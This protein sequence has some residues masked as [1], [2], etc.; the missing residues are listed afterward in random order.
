MFQT[1]VGATYVP[2]KNNKVRRI[3]STEAVVKKIAGDG[4]MDGCVGRDGEESS[5]VAQGSSKF[6]LNCVQH[7]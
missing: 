4:W 2:Q 7:Y 6:Y 3:C 5:G 1:V